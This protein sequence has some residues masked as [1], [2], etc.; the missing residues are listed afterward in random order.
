MFC[1]FAMETIFK[2]ICL[3]YTC[4]TLDTHC[5]NIAK[6]SRLKIPWRYGCGHKLPNH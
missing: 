5:Y 6:Q 2:V 4:H 1:N 3:G